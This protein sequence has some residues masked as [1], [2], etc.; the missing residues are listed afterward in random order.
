MLHFGPKKLIIII[1]CV[2]YFTSTHFNLRVQVI[3]SLTTN[4]PA[5]RAGVKDGD[6][7]IEVNGTNV[8]EKTHEEIVE[9][10]RECIPTNEISFKLVD[11]EHD[12]RKRKVERLM[13]RFLARVLNF[14]TFCKSV[15]AF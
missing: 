7:L 3:T 12:E 11:E 15:L 2:E 6:R 4:G 14:F 8:E 1:F 5:Y 10:I 13:V 9:M